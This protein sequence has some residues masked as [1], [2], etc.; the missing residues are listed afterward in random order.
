MFPQKDNILIDLRTYWVTFGTDKH[1]GYKNF[2]DFVLIFL[3]ITSKKD[4]QK[5]KIILRFR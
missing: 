2:Y 3:P 5:F 1:N 4:L